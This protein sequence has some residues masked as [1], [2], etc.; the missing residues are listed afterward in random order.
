MD[1]VIY[2]DV[3]R[4]FRAPETTTIQIF[5]S[6]LFAFAGGSLNNAMQ[7][8]TPTG[9][10]KWIG[11]KWGDTT[12][13]NVSLILDEVSVYN[14]VV[15]HSTDILRTI[16]TF[17]TPEQLVKLW[18]MELIETKPEEQGITL[19]Q[20]MDMLSEWTSQ[21]KFIGK[22]KPEEKPIEECKLHWF[23]EV[24]GNEND[25]FCGYCHKSCRIIYKEDKP[26]YWY[27]ETEE[28]KKSEYWEVFKEWYLKNADWKP[29]FKAKSYWFNK[30]R[31]WD[32]WMNYGNPLSPQQWYDTIYDGDKKCTHNNVF[33]CP[34]CPWYIKP[35]EWIPEYHDKAM[36][37]QEYDTVWLETPNKKYAIPM[38]IYK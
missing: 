37:I 32:Y 25:I 34:K 13:D 27:I 2:A 19:W 20:A 18:Y 17:H 36:E 12:I 5:H 24:Y 10:Y 3:R 9:T 29:D 22:T 28:M 4:E 33:L 11:D 15:V 6:Y 23:W 21:V 16:Y 30:L 1:P 7:I 26:T 35:P 31:W 38:R 8:T 14:C